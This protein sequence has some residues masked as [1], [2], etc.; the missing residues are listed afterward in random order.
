MEDKKKILVVDL[1]LRLVSAFRQHSTEGRPE[2]MCSCQS[3]FME[4]CA[5][6]ENVLLSKKSIPVAPRIPQLKLTNF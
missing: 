5:H 6:L 3:D 1:T 2:W 4:T